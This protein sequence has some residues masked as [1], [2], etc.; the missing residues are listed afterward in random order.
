MAC[1]ERDAVRLSNCQSTL[2][3]GAALPSGVR[4]TNRHSREGGN[5]SRIHSAGL[6]KC[7]VDGLDSG[8][9]GNDGDLVMTDSSKLTEQSENVYEN[10]QSRS[11][12]VEELRS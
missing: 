4:R 12:G 9:R 1:G 7:P 11:L 5:P 10:K 8:F 2:S 6:A 3:L